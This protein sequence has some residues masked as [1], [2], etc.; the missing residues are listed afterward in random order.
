MGWGGGDR[1]SGVI[2]WNV[3]LRIFV[4]SE[5]QDLW[6]TRVL[7]TKLFEPSDIITIDCEASGFSE[8]CHL[9]IG[10]WS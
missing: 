5:M 1:P 7:T 2:I 8:T 3:I 6:N 9:G 10:G 4:L